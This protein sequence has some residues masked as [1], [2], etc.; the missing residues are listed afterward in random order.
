MFTKWQTE[1][2]V[3]TFDIDN[4]IFLKST[5][6]QSCSIIGDFVNAILT[7]DFDFVFKHEFRQSKASPR[8]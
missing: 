7:F 6:A 4:H 8:C 2:S 1:A 3:Y 5:C